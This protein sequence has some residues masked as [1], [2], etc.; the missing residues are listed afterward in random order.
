MGGGHSEQGMPANEF[1]R[2]GLGFRCGLGFM[3]VRIL[4]ELASRIDHFDPGRDMVKGG[5]MVA[6]A[7]KGPSGRI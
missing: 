3:G 5:K 4:V 6:A 2:P 7:R 1:T